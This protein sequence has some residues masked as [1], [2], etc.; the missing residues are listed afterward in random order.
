MTQY[1]NIAI[2][3]KRLHDSGYAG[4]LALVLLLPPAMLVVGMATGVYALASIAVLV[5]LAFTIWL[6]VVPGASGPNR[7]GGAPDVPPA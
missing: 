4:T 6:G 7:F 1:C 5:A 2:V 3:V